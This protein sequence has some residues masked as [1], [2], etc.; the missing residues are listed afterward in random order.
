M[1]TPPALKQAEM[2]A[3]HTAQKRIVEYEDGNPNYIET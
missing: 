2:L 3:P 1:K